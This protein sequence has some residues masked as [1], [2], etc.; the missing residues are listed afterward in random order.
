MVNYEVVGP[1]LVINPQDIDPGANVITAP[2]LK[3]N[4]VYDRFECAVTFYYLARNFPPGVGGVGVLLIDGDNDLKWELK[5]VFQTNDRIV[6]TNP[7]LVIDKQGNS[8]IV[9]YA[10]KLDSS[11]R[12]VIGPIFCARSLDGGLSWDNPVRVSESGGDIRFNIAVSDIPGQI[13]VVWDLGS[14]IL[15]DRSLDYGQTFG[16][17]KLVASYQRDQRGLRKFYPGIA[18]KGQEIFVSFC[19]WPDGQDPN[20]YLTKSDDYIT[21]LAPRRVNDDTNY[22]FSREN[23]ASVLHM[24][25]SGRLRIFWFDARDSQHNNAFMLMAADI[26]SFNEYPYKNYNISDGP[27]LLGNLFS[28]RDPVNFDFVSIDENGQ[29]LAWTDYQ[30]RANGTTFANVRVRRCS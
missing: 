26:I 25:S 16:Q 24:D 21:W 6:Y 13:Y 29:L 18:I 5:K 3:Y 7:T 14:A 8:F 27:S 9:W 1:E 11:E 22:R 12:W 23:V 19:S 15:I 17:D 30:K 4:P 10:S 28:F 2:S 20:V